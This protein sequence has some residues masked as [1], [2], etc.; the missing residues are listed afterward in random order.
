MSVKYCPLPQLTLLCPGP[1]S[2]TRG[3][4]SAFVDAA[5]SHRAQ[6]FSS[7]LHSVQINLLEVAGIA[8]VKDYLALVISGS[9]TAANEAVL[10]SVVDSGR[11]VL[12]LSNG[13]FGERLGGVSRLYHPT[14]CLA[15]A[16]GEIIDLAAVEDCLKQHKPGLVAM[17]HHETSTGILNP[18]AEVG[19]LCRH[20]GAELFVDMVSSFSA[21]PLDLETADVSFATTSAGKAIGAYPGLS[22]VIARRD[23]FT[24]ILN[25]PQYNHYLSLPRYFHFSEYHGQSP[26]TPAVSLIAATA[27]A[28]QEI[29]DEGLTARHQRLQRLAAMVRHELKNRKLYESPAGP[30]SVVVTNALLPPGMSFTEL[31]KNLHQAGYVV[32]DAKGPLQGK[33]FQISTIGDIHP[34]QI[35]QFFTVL[36]TQFG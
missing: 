5:F 31:Q 7:L 29:L 16:W 32:Y 2:V 36:D 35:E 25:R 33:Y 28:L 30:Q 21:D 24:K 11:D 15:C 10:T 4:A 17:V 12:V 6:N 8:Q 23:L 9:G 20:Y 26:N 3:V 1:V 18:V 27:V 34:V 22:F 19:Q 14:R 13:E